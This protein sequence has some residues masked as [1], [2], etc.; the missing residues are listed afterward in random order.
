[1]TD[2][3]PVIVLG[4][5]GYV[6]G[7][8]LRLIALHPRLEAA[9]VI[10]SSRQG[11]SI[12][13]A[14]GHLASSYPTKQ[15][16]SEKQAIDM[17]Q[18]ASKWITIS[19]APHGA[20]ARLIDNFLNKA[21]QS[22]VE[23]CVVDASADFRYSSSERFMEV[24]GQAHDAPHR[25]NSFSCAV[26]EHLELLS[27]PHAAQPGCFATSML[28]SIVPL[29][30]LDLAKPEFFVS[31]ITGST[32]AGR[33]PRDTTHHP[34]RQ[35]NL[36][37]YK[38]LSHRHHPEV[39]DIARVCTGSDISLNFIPKSG[40][41]SRGIYATVFATCSSEADSESITAEVS[42]F[43]R[44][45]DFVTVES[46]PPKLKDVVGT[47][48]AVLS[49]SVDN[50]TIAVCCAIDNLVKGA[51]GGAIQWANRLAGWPDSEGLK[52]VPAGWV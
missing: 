23:M 28:L 8:L 25:L 38:P 35:S 16:V 26:P 30:K 50:G 6:A 27:T 3:T 48:N 15:F 32:G 4:G 29:L 45:S 34:M 47:N 52:I 14:F 39:C 37:A 24:Y 41:F 2:K 1:M 44:D 51:A 13:A 40:P 33:T 17:L 21:E 12:S 42:K 11:E 22:N 46:T 49:I 19:A 7:E 36:F 20:S 31:A 9:S 18:N 43:Y 5:S 10:S